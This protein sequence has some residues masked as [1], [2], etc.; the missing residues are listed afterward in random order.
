MRRIND[1]LAITGAV[2]SF[3]LGVGVSL[4]ASEPVYAAAT[5]SIDDLLDGPPVLTSVGIPAGV[6][7]IQNIVATAESLSFTYDDLVVAGASRTRLVFLSEAESSFASDE[8]SWGVIE[9]QSVETILF[10]SDLDPANIPIPR[11]CVFNPDFFQ[12]SCQVIP[13]TG[14]FQL[15]L[16]VPATGTAYLVRSAVDVPEPATIFLLGTGLLALA[17]LRR[18]ARPATPAGGA[19]S[20]HR[21]LR[22]TLVVCCALANAPAFAQTCPTAD[23]AI[24]DAKSHKLFLY[25]PTASDSTFPAFP[26]LD[27]LF[28]PAQPFD[29][30]A[31]SPGIG[32]TT[33]LIEEIH[34][35]VV[36]DYCEFNVQVLATTTN[37]NTMP[38]P[39]ARRVTVAIGSD[40]ND[41]AWG[42]APPTVDTNDM[43]DVDFARVWAGT[44]T[45]CE[46]GTGMP[47]MCSMTGA[48]TGANA[49]LEH[50]AEAIGGTAAHEGGHTYGLAHTN[51]D[52]P[53]GLCGQ[54]GPAPL[55]GE[56]AFN[57]HLMPAGCYLTGPDR[58]NFR[59]HFSDRTYGLLATNVG[60]SIE[61]MHNWDMVNPN[62][63]EAKSLVID[64]LSPLVT[65]PMIAWT[66]IG[67]IG[68]TPASPWINPTVTGPLG[69]MMFPPGRGTTYNKFQITWSEANAAFPSPGV[70]AGGTRFHVGTTFTG[71]D[72]RQPDPIIIQNVTLFKDDKSSM[73]LPLNP[74][75]PS[76]DA[77]TL[78]AAN[79]QFVVNFFAPANA[80]AL[81]L[82]SATISQLPR[83]ATIDS[84][85]GDGSPFT[86]DG[87][88][89]EPWSSTTCLTSVPSGTAAAAPVPLANG[90]RCGVAS[91]DQPPNVQV[92]YQVGQPGVIDCRPSLNVPP[93]VRNGSRLDSTSPNDEALIC[94]GVQRDPFPSAT[95]YVVATF[96]DPNATH[97]DPDTNRFV[98]GPVTSKV[99]YQFAGIRGLFQPLRK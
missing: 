20:I 54:L 47:N 17:L 7:G 3:T 71:V 92:V 10:R 74:R 73:P 87:R 22:A 40:K 61:T 29:V 58:A 98:V 13:E 85:V 44:Y 21:M 79:N 78:D 4:L 67:P 77:G 64:F 41:S 37:P 86:R 75:L 83:V 89:I 33:E 38:M 32:T 52:P 55:P 93:P 39:P 16:S 94:V 18:R 91:L 90:V 96:V 28:S 95:V 12:N 56:D 25:F 34:T 57:R 5:I 48:L 81:L 45:V 49:T 99:F 31:L 80:P 72:Y 97:Y 60:L 69:T 30:A 24:D 76:Y 82:T 26:S 35:V 88:P 42:L 51:D 63:E 11:P 27:P 50:W 8:F 59:R 43:R 53:M 46:G 1:L 15:V 14:D 84:L 70:V 36:D 6:P 9:G 66:Y 23:P 2:I 68:S 65:P 19:Y 62:A